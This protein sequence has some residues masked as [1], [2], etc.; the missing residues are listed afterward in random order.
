MCVCE[1]ERESVCVR[2]CVRMFVCVRV[3]VL[4]LKDLK[5]MWVGVCMHVC[6]CVCKCV[7]VCVCHSAYVCVCVCF[8]L[9]RPRLKVWRT[10]TSC[11]FI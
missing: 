5:R 7:C 10:K 6:E 3:S 4:F 8:V 9:E 11:I 2:V 1:R